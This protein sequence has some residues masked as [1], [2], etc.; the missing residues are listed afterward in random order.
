MR[1]L[2]LRT[3]F[4]VLLLA[5]WSTASFGYDYSY[6]YIQGDLET[7]FYV[8]LEGQMLPRLG[9]NYCIIPNLDTGLIHVQILFQQNVYPEQE[10]A[11]R[12]PEAGAR[13]FALQK[14]NDQQFA[15]YDLQSGNYLI[16]GNKDDNNSMLPNGVAGNS[17]GESTLELPPFRESGASRG[18]SEQT[19][20]QERFIDDVELR[21]AGTAVDELPAFG[22]S[23]PPKKTKE[24]NNRQLME[25]SSGRVVDEDLSVGDHTIFTPAPTPPSTPEIAIPNS[26]C[27]T[28]MSN[29]AFE[30]LALNVLDKNDDLARLKFI[31]KTGVKY[32]YTTEQVRILASNIQSPSA[33]YE[34]V[35]ALYP[36][37]VDHAEFPKLEAL[38][39]TTYLRNKFL[40]AINK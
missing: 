38:F 25:T 5:G 37:V 24:R 10:F 17:W 4:A 9:K 21:S 13:G 11:I 28:A 27:P 40:A 29:S 33:R 32:C 14:I 20:T 19:R 6:I 22:N 2:L 34:M 3:L 23:I 31:N 30:D 39:K 35:I 15:L 18:N 12:V 7:P 26:D 36:R 16:A 1:K 8:K